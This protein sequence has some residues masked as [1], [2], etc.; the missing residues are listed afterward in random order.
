MILA[1]VIVCSVILLAA[2]GIVIVACFGAY[3]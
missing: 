2:A 1:T 3:E